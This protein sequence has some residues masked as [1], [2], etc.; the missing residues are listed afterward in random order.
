[1]SR[2]IVTTQLHAVAGTG[3]DVDGYADRLV[4]F[5][6]GDVVAGWLTLKSVIAAAAQPSRSYYWLSFLALCLLTAI[7]TWRQTSKTGLPTATTQIGVSTAAF[8]IWSFALGEPFS[9]FA[10]YSPLLASVVLIL[11]TLFTGA[12]APKE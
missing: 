5:I 3:G 8:G 4:K 10:W 9:G 2:R 6:P 7:W 1:M 11:F 12:L